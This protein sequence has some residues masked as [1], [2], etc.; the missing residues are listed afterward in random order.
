M[1]FIY[2]CDMVPLERFFLFLFVVFVE[3]IAKYDLRERV[4]PY[5]LVYSNPLF[6]KGYCEESDSVPAQL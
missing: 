2:K 1:V 3:A 4:I 6:S 5:H